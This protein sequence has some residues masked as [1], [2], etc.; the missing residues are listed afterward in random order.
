MSISREYLIIPDNVYIKV[1]L[2]F[3]KWRQ[4][5]SAYHTKSDKVR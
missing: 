5:G 4:A 1:I 2:F 3:C